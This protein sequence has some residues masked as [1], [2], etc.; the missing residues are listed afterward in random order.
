LHVDD[1]TALVLIR[2]FPPPPN[3]SLFPLPAGANAFTRRLA[4]EQIGNWAAQ[5][6]ADSSGLHIRAILQRLHPFIGAREWETRMAAGH[7]VEALARS[8]SP[9]PPPSP[10]PQMSP[11]SISEL[12]PRPE[13]IR[14]SFAELDMAQVI[15]RGRPLLASGGAEFEFDWSTVEPRKRLEMERQ[16]LKQRLGL[17][18]HVGIE[19]ASTLQVCC[20]CSAPSCSDHCSNR[21]TSC[22][23]SIF[24]T[25]GCAFVCDGR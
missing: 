2:F 25:V 17:A 1:R 22:F 24:A 9:P 4:A 8:W 16:L 11:S 18:E 15:A 23:L 12:P 20:I 5:A 14:L 21:L 7:A 13:R 10:P 3:I 6:A 19:S